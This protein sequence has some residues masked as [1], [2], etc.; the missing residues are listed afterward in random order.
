M[1]RY[2]MDFFL[3]KRPFNSID[4]HFLM[5][6]ALVKSPMVQ[7][8]AIFKCI[9]SHTGRIISGTLLH[10]LNL[11]E[12]KALYFLEMHQKERRPLKAEFPLF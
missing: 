2:T 11:P 3:K 12:L 5:V 9:T 10:S 6:I 1:L 8:K 4:I 7:T